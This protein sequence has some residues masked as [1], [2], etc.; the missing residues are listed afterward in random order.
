MVGEP[1][2]QCL[3]GIAPG[4]LDQL[5]Q[6]PAPGLSD[7]DLAPRL[8]REGFLEQPGLARLEADQHE[9][10]RQALAVEL[11]EEGGQHVGGSASLVCAG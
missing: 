6:R 10:R 1:P 8:E 9:L 3:P 11:G 5:A 2:G 7:L 4:A